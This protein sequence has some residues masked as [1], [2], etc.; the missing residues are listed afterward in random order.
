MD[1]SLQRACLFPCLTLDVRMYS[2][3]SQFGH[4]AGRWALREM[5]NTTGEKKWTDK[6]HH[7]ELCAFSKSE[8]EWA[9]QLGFILCF[10]VG[11][12]LLPWNTWAIDSYTPI[13]YDSPWNQLLGMFW[14]TDKDLCKTRK[15]KS[16][17]TFTS[18]IT[19]SHEKGGVQ[20]S[21]WEGNFTTNVIELV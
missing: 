9:L 12:R 1:R 3:P 4:T 7:F 2:L 5:E 8:L 16:L 13:K 14:V 15:S 10:N 20:P 19:A 11:S 18:T 17:L 6:Q 21:L